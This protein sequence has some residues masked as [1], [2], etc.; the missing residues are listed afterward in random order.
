MRC[1]SR[2]ILG[3]TRVRV[4]ARVSYSRVTIQLQ[5]ANSLRKQPFLLVLRLYSMNADSFVI[6][7]LRLPLTFVAFYLLSVI[8]KQ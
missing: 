5:S 7:S 3:S 4:R 6:D 2:A 8:R 1:S